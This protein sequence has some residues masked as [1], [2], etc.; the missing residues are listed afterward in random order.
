MRYHG[1]ISPASTC[2]FVLSD[3]PCEWQSIVQGLIVS[4][5]GLTESVKKASTAALLD[6]CKAIKASGTLVALVRLSKTTL[7]LFEVR[8]HRAALS[9]RHSCVGCSRIFAVM[10]A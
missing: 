4:L 10:T 1:P 8:F 9:V 5:G 2:I 3:A 6:W 7:K